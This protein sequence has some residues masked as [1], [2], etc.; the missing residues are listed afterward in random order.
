MNCGES[1]LDLNSITGR[2]R[3]WWIVLIAYFM[4]ES[5]VH[6]QNI[7]R[8]EYFFD[9]DPGPGNGI[10]IT[11]PVPAETVTFSTTLSTTGLSPGR[12]LCYI[13]TKSAGGDWSLYEPRVF[14]I[15]VP[16]R[17]AEYFIDTDPGVGNATPISVSTVDD[18]VFNTSIVLP[19]LPD[20]THY[21]FIRI[22]DETGAWSLYE[23]ASFDVDS[24]LPIELLSF[25]AKRNSEGAVELNWVTATEKN[26]D[27]FEIERWIK[28]DPRFPDNFTTIG[29]IDGSGTSTEQHQYVY[30]DNPAKADFVYYRLKQVDLDG[31]F[32][33]SN[34]VAISGEDNFFLTVYPN[35]SL[36]SF[37]LQ[38]HGK[39]YDN[40]V[41][42]IADSMGKQ[43]ETYNN[44]N[45]PVIFGA[46]WSP[47]LYVVRLRNADQVTV[48]KIAKAH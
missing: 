29:T 14:F 4:F 6:A 19:M 13:R 11:V 7:N 17:R 1:L 35:P 46:N 40:V 48:L 18:F 42:E 31:E 16:V 47:G 26:N 20:G 43:I 28:G 2:Q 32:T 12:H 38:I 23:P 45:G 25:T 27:H 5:S 22:K 24:V 10:P 8:A 30:L 3:T 34:V 9:V 44:I 41:V 33:Y 39:K 15:Q 36:T 21:L 37:T